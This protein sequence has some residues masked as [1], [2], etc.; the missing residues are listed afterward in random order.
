MLEFC[1]KLGQ[2]PLSVSHYLSYTLT[3]SALF[4]IFTEVLEKIFQTDFRNTKAIVI[5]KS[6]TYLMCNL[7]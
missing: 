7:L 2:N 4:S 5:K 6:K 3:F 1:S